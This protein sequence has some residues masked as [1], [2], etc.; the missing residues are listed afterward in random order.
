MKLKK[1][2]DQIIFD[3]FITT[4]TGTVAGVN[5]EPTFEDRLNKAIN[6]NE[7]H[8]ILGHP[9]ENITRNTAQ[10]KL[11]VVDTMKECHECALAKIKQQKISKETTT[12]SNVPGERLC[13]DISSV[14]SPS[15]GGAKFWLLIIND[16]TRMCWST[17]LKHKSE[18]SE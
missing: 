4:D 12:R 14:R 13:I 5:M 15:Y 3:R 6:I 17:F 2:S 11:Q 18:T 7:L 16:V 10:K 1:G 9:S 8:M